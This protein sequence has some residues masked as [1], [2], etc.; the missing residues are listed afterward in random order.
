[1]SWIGI[2]LKSGFIV[3]FC[4]QTDDANPVNQP[5]ACATEFSTLYSALPSKLPDSMAK[6][7]SVSIC[8]VCL[9]HLAN[10]KVSLY[11][12]FSYSQV[13]IEC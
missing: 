9:L 6:N 8:F 3:T 11:P 12:I 13:C 2:L 7:V 1:M 4:I 10:E 5:E